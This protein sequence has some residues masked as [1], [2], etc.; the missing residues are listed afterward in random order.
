MRS[1]GFMGEDMAAVYLKERGSH[2]MYRNFYTRF[3]ELDIIAKKGRQLHIIEVKLTHRTTIHSSYKLNKHKQKRMIRC[4]QLY[5]DYA[6]IRD[7]YIQFDLI[8][9]THNQINHYPNIFNLTDTYG[10]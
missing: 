10:Q 1:K 6:H 3:G 7:M 9:I 2:I 5:L 8:A 4:T